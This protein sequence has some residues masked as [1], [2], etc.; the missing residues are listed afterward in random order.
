MEHSLRL[1]QPVWFADDRRK[2]DDLLKL[3]R[4]LWQNDDGYVLCEVVLHIY[5][6]QHP[7]DPTLWRTKAFAEPILLDQLGNVLNQDYWS[8]DATND[9]STWRP[10]GWG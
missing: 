8:Y 1:D 9:I 7:L 2:T 3:T 5:D 10:F 6:D 4:V